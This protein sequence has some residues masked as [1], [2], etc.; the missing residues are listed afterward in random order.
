MKFYEITVGLFGCW[1]YF[2]DAY[3]SLSPFHLPTYRR[4]VCI[5]THISCICRR[6]NT[7]R[8]NLI[9]RA[10]YILAFSWW[11]KV[12]I[13]FPSSFEMV[14]TISLSY[15]LYLFGLLTYKI[16]FFC[17]SAVIFSRMSRREKKEGSY[18]NL[19]VDSFYTIDK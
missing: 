5:G 16:L 7:T 12:W 2:Y 1:V 3:A 18:K 13:I 10:V 17:Y 11:E 15:N 9:R 8:K 6:N 14:S 19:V 4:R